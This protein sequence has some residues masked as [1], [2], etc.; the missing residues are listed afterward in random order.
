M[1]P[2][3]GC[4]SGYGFYQIFPPM[5]MKKPWQAHRGLKLGRYEAMKFG[6][7]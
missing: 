6:E 3:P 5:G 7:A 2:P 1:P 4:F